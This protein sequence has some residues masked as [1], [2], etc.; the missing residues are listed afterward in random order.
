MRKACVS[1]KK[2]PPLPHLALSCYNIDAVDLPGFERDELESESCNMP[3]KG[4]A[5]ADAAGWGNF[6]G[7][8]QGEETGEE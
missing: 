1:K 3:H 8:V 6:S 5:I 2:R 4:F 7:M